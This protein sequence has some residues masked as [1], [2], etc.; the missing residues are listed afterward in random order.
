MALRQRGC[1]KRT[2]LGARDGGGGAG[3]Q[4]DRQRSQRADWWRRRRHPAPAFASA[5]HR[6]PPSRHAGGCHAQAPRPVRQ[7]QLQRQ[8]QPNRHPRIRHAALWSASPCPG[9]CTRHCGSV[10]CA[11]R[12]GNRGRSFFCFAPHAQACA[13][14]ARPG[15]ALQ[16]S[17][18]SS[19][20]R[21]L[22]GRCGGGGAA[23]PCARSHR[24]ARPGGSAN[25]RGAGCRLRWWRQLI[26]AQLPLP[27]PTAKQHPGHVAQGGAP[28]RPRAVYRTR[29]VV[30]WRVASRRHLFSVPLGCAW[31]TPSGAVRGA[32]HSPFA[33]QSL[34]APNRQTRPYTPFQPARYCFTLPAAAL[35]TPAT[36]RSSASL[37][38]CP[39]PPLPVLSAPWPTAAC[40][41]R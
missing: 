5:L 21:S 10:R 38:A 2:G 35:A 17:A 7:R 20:R 11:Q 32:R 24:C 4:A 13:Q 23:G 9:P 29:M 30:L 36:H 19:P 8:R 39:T 6:H 22:R 25:C 27:F 41:R 16:R 28:H 37:L 3:R 31:S 14:Q 40:R 12:L 15:A 18:R 33:S 26:A 34:V 1:G